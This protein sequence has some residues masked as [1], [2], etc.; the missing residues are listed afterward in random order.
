[1]T[2]KQTKKC[3]KCGRDLPLDMYFK[4]KRYR[5]GLYSYCRDCH[6]ELTR[7][8][9]YEKRMRGYNKELTYD[10]KTVKKFC[11]S[12]GQWLGLE[13]FYNAPGLTYGASTYCRRCTRAKNNIYYRERK[14]M[15]KELQA[16]VD[17]M[18][19]E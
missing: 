17:K 12:C 13:H 15:M 14:R 7:R 1:M 10:P 3:S 19:S 4:D 2:D 9:Y 11:S 18:E 16:K 6:A 5:D 8:N